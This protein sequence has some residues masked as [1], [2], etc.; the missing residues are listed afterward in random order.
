[1][2]SFYYNIP[3]PFL[4]YPH[5]YVL[6][7]LSVSIPSPSICIV[8]PLHFYPIPIHMYCIPSPFLS[9]PQ[10]FSYLSICSTIVMKRKEL[11]QI[12]KASEGPSDYHPS[13]GLTSGSSLADND[14]LTQKE[15][16]GWWPRRY[17][18]QNKSMTGG[19]LTANRIYPCAMVSAQLAT[20]RWCGSRPTWRDGMRFR[21][22]T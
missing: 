3:S 20:T 1:M 10:P 4:S 18:S 13:C 21:R 19:K 9:H 22:C 2:N 7:T 11:F 16:S 15:C 8:Y 17:I 6:Y 5:P 12:S 14:K